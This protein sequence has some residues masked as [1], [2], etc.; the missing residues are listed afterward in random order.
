MGENETLLRVVGG[1]FVD[2]ISLGVPH[3]RY[4]LES[5]DGCSNHARTVVKTRY[6]VLFRGVGLEHDRPTVV[7]ECNDGFKCTF[8]QF[9]H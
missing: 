5:P 4:P 2:I 3:C 6:P 7:L 1:V 8:V 9:P